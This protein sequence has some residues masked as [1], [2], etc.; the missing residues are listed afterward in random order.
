MLLGRLH[1]EGSG[2]LVQQLEW[3]R[4]LR[5]LRCLLQPIPVSPPLFQQYLTAVLPSEQTPANVG[6]L[7]R[8][9]HQLLNHADAAEQARTQPGAAKALFHRLCAPLTPE[10][11]A[12]VLEDAATPSPSPAAPSPLGKRKRCAS[13]APPP[14]LSLKSF[15]EVVSR[16]PAIQ[17]WCKQQS[18][19]SDWEATIRIYLYAPPSQV[20]ARLARDFPVSSTHTHTHTSSLHAHMLIRV[21]T[22]PLN[23]SCVH[24]PRKPALLKLLVLLPSR[25]ALPQPSL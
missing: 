1:E 2:A 7:L 13:T 5:R 24:R 25:A 16:L 3:Y 19:R 14:Q 9:L 4:L 12:R 17:A 15:T 8:K 10:E 18:P 11:A 23:L 20:R 6:E 22:T 21:L